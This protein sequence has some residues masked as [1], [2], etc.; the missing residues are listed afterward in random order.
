MEPS[1]FGFNEA[2]SIP[3]MK[4]EVSKESKRDKGKQRCLEDDAMQEIEGK[5]LSTKVYLTPSPISY[6]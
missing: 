3:R 1:S 6:A 2:T 4:L 5:S